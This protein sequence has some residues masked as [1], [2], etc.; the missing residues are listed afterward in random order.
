M[1]NA[2]HNRS[3]TN[4]DLKHL[5]LKGVDINERWIKLYKVAQDTSLKEFIE[6]EGLIFKRGCAFYEFTHS[7]ES[8]MAESDTEFLFVPKVI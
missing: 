8:I 7:V 6:E 3:L 2:D 5:M 1:C 4:D